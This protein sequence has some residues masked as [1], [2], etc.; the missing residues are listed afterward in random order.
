[1]RKSVIAGCLLLLVLS[2]GPAVHAQLDVKDIIQRSVEANKADW[3]VQPDYDHCIR[4]KED[5][6]VK[7][8][9]VLMILGSPYQRL[10]ALDGKPLSPQQ[11]KQ[12]ESKLQQEIADRRRETP[13]QRAKRIADWERSR[14]RNHLLLEQLTKAFDFKM[15]GDRKVE[16]HEVYELAATPRPGY[17][18]P[19]NQAKVLTGMEGKLWIDQK[20]FQWVKVEAKVIHPVS[21]AGFMARVEKGTRFELR[22]APVAPDIWFPS[23]FA[24]KARA[25]ILFVIPHNNQEQDT[26]FNYRKAGSDDSPGLCLNPPPQTEAHQ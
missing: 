4:V 1:M 5:S 11:E 18:P 26:Y 22:Q 8:Y 12:E 19:N 16:G 20:S 2:F 14:Q 3:K 10:V 21:I 6:K 15:E 17:Q 7:T 24:V 25:K 23:Y 13:Q 9:D